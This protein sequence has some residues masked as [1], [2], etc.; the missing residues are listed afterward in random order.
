M[1]H[2]VTSNTKSM[3]YRRRAPLS[4]LVALVL[5]AL[6]TYAT[7]VEAVHRHGIAPV[8]TSD[9]SAVAISSTDDANSS[10]NQSRATG[11]CLICQLRQQLSFSLLNAPSLL[12]APQA[13]L[14]RAHAAAL[15]S[16]SRPDTPQC[17]R[18]PPP[19]SLF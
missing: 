17:G 2:Q 7:T 1:L 8:I 11:E 4:R 18:A 19:I 5:L 12:L 10:A 9:N 15:P 16:F 13:Q 6:V 3:T 14:A